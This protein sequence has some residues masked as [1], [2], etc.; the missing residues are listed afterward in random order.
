MDK[1]EK[2]R[3]GWREF[4]LFFFSVFLIVLIL[5]FIDD[6]ISFPNDYYLVQ[7]LHLIF[8][9]YSNEEFVSTDFRYRVSINSIGIRDK[10]I[11]IPK[12]KDTY[13]IL[14]FGDSYTYGW[15][16]NIEDTWV[17]R[18]EHKVKVEG[19]NVETVNLGKP[20]A[21]PLFYYELAKVAIPILEPD[22]ILI[23]LLQGDDLLAVCGSE[24]K[25]T[26]DNFVFKALNRLF[27]NISK[28]I[29]KY[30]TQKYLIEKTE[31]K[32]ALFNSAEKNQEAA[33]SSAR[34]ILAQFN[35]KERESFNTLDKEIRSAFLDGLINPF[36]ISVAIKNPKV[37]VIPLED[38]SSPT[39]KPC[40]EKLTQLLKDIAVM[41]KKSGAETIVV[42][43]PQGFYV[44]QYAWENMKRFHFEVSP[45]MLTTDNVD[46][47]FI[48][49]AEQ[50][51]LPCFV[52]TQE[53]RE[54]KDNPELFFPIDGHPTPK[55]HQL[56]SEILFK[57]LQEWLEKH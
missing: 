45:E 38:S 14:V 30:L 26:K 4:C 28:S 9:K 5:H 49:S 18:L 55:G 16:V 50:A 10:E 11:R 3:F 44:N 32:P 57:K 19:K 34:E 31:R 8:P 35:E 15:G 48:L 41:G 12:D 56:I 17:R 40:I 13:R 33:R 6:V 21:D 1:K 43:I 23:A 47:H 22:L 20:G 54:Q 27:P 2:V 42:S 24:V 7:G 29:Q 36:L 39:I 37:T 46:K 25:T 51:S 53:F 52:L